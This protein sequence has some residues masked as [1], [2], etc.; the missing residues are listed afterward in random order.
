MHPHA[1]DDGCHG[2][3]IAAPSLSAAGDSWGRKI[4]GRV[5]TCRPVSPRGRQVVHPRREGQ[6]ESGTRS[7]LV[8]Y[9]DEY[10]D[11]QMISDRSRL[12]LNRPC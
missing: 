2:A 6:F 3:G 8:Y 11:L 12:H 7:T 9:D 10:S 5:T 4:S 1:I